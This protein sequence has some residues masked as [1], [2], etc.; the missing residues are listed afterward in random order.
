MSKSISFNELLETV[1]YLT[2]DEQESFIDI[3]N[4]RIAYNR[5]Q[6]IHK[7]VLSARNEYKNGKL[8]PESPQDIMNSII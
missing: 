3:L 6:E 5:R 2:L 4:R 7:L 1:E 8:K